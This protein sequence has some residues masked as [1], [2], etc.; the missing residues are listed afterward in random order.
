VS[1]SEFM[2]AVTHETLRDSERHRA[3]QR[4]WLS[5][6]K[7]DWLTED[8]YVQKI[9]PQLGAVTIAT[10]S[11]TLGVSE[12]YAA[13]IRAGRHRPHPRHWQALANLAGVVPGNT[14][15]SKFPNRFLVL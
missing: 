7:S 13:D 4:A 9:Q 15:S 3:A 1:R 8:T 14:E 5:A 11:T 12:S 2:G 10:I 6:P